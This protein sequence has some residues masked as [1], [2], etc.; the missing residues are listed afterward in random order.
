ME[1]R[2]ALCA[3]VRSHRPSLLAVMGCG[4]WAKCSRQGAGGGVP[5]WCRGST[6]ELR[7]GT[8]LYRKCMV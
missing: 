6:L 1:L 7:Y 8:P 3:A 2:S 4:E 5:F